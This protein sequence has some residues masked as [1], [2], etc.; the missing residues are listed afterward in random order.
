MARYLVVA[1]QTATSLELIDRL[2]ELVH[3]DD[4]VVL[5]VPATPT[6]DLLTWQEGGHE[7]AQRVAVRSLAL[8]RD[9]GLH[10]EDAIV[11]D[12]DPLRAVSA[13]VASSGRH[14][15]KI[16]ISTLP[17]GISR[18]LKQGLPRQAER[19][20]GIPVMHVVVHRQAGTAPNRQGDERND[21]LSEAWELR[22]LG[23]WRGRPVVTSDGHRLRHVSEIIYD[24]VTTRPVWIG[25]VDGRKGLTPT[26]IP[27]AA[28]VPD[29]DHLR[30]GYT[31][32]FLMHAPGVS[33]GEGFSSL[34]DESALYDYF[35][36]PFDQSSDL[37]VLREGQAY[38]DSL[39]YPGAA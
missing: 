1:N 31:W 10:P 35:G 3:E 30:V 21:L 7:Q 36:V 4:S 20:L 22:R 6:Q 11:G 2:K 34:T 18:W 9:A 33:V 32:S 8:L 29:G 16:V 23:E 25:A 28:S 24:P 17:L 5:L 15:D 26:L 27:A 13:E 14:Y 12:P 37:R 39:A 19:R 38:P